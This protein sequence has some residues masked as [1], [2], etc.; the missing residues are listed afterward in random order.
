VAIACFGLAL[1]W[2]GV[3][4]LAGVSVETGLAVA[5][6]ILGLGLVVGSFLGGARGLI[7][8]GFLVTAA[9]VGT[10]ALDVPLT[11]GVGDRTWF[12]EDRAAA[13]E[14]FRLA[15][16]DARLDL[17]SLR[18][19]EERTVEVEATVAIGH[20]VVVVP[21]DVPVEVRARVNAGDLRVFA[22]EEDG[23]DVD[24]EHADRDR[25]GV[26]TIIIDAGVG[27]GQVEVIR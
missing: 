1:L 17:R 16:G 24:I 7:F 13:A 19:G 23:I 18:P 8:P 9:L 27:L 11:G 4:V 2:G 22:E 14:P 26:G 15:V 6:G 12:V 25:P 21:E 20:L 5:A 3:A 10:A